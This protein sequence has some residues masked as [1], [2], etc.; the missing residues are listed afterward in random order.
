M[1]RIALLAVLAACGGD[2][3]AGTHDAAVP[4]IPDA[5]AIAPVITS[6][7]A[8]PATKQIPAGVPTKVT[9]NWT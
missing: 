5:A 2:D 9:W 8:M 6:F 3:A 4:N 1:K 7:T